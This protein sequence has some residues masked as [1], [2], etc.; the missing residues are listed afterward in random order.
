MS[1]EFEYRFPSCAV[2]ENT[3]VGQA[4]HA[5]EEVHEAVIELAAG[6]RDAAMVELLDAVHAIET[7]LRM[8][9]CTACELTTAWSKVFRKNAERG[10]Y[11]QGR[12]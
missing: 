4:N 9:E 2:R 11:K 3:V 8:M 10:Y 5:A 12:A 6:D 7:T 1:G